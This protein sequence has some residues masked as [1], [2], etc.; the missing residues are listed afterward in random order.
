MR[1][2]DAVRIA[3][4]AVDEALEVRRGCQCHRRSLFP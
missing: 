2:Q 4:L 1:A 3:V